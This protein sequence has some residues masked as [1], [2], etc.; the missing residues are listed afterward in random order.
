[1]NHHFYDV[2]VFV[3]FEGMIRCIWVRNRVYEETAKRDFPDRIW[4]DFFVLT[5]KET[6]L[7][8]DEDQTSFR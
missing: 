7:V 4:P 8:F 5:K 2:E 3:S 6:R 1:M